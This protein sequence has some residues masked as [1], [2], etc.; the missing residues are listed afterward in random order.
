MLGCRGGGLTHHEQDNE[1][2]DNLGSSEVGAMAFSKALSRRPDAA[3]QNAKVGREDDHDGEREG[4]DDV[5]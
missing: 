2:E 5:E 3:L 4:G 1:Q